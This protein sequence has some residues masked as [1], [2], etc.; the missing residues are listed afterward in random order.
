MRRQ[1]ITCTAA[2]SFWL[3]L[4]HVALRNAMG[5]SA[6]GI[7]NRQEPYKDY[8]CTRLFKVFPRLNLLEF[9]SWISVLFCTGLDHCIL[10]FTVQPVAS[11]DCNVYETD[12][13]VLTCTVESLS[14][15]DIADPQDILIKWFFFNDTEYELTVGINP[16]Q[17][18]GG[19]GGHVTV[20]STL[21]ISGTSQPNASYV[22]EG[23]YHCQVQMIDTSVQSQP[24][25][26]FEVFNRDRYLQTVTSCSERTFT[27]PL[28]SCAVYRIREDTPTT[29]T[30]INATTK[31]DGQNVIS[32]TTMVPSESQSTPP[33][34][35]NSVNN[36][37]GRALPIWVY[38]LIALVVVFAVIIVVLATVVISVLTKIRYYQATNDEGKY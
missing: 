29:T 18:T 37:G 4:V 22:S 9:L 16:P 32:G 6:Q 31:T 23:F 28:Q 1:V 27:A 5:T 3:L 10:N 26:K 21:H 36:E 13:E 15:A 30:A 24:S 14:T 19:N 11:V 34:P 38:I 8:Y 33:P 25:Q 2:F 7:K 20:T 12:L 35:P 17:R